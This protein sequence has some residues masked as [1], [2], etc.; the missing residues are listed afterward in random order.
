MMAFIAAYLPLI[1]LSD[2]FVSNT[3]S[4]SLRGDEAYVTGLKNSSITSVTV[5]ATVVY[6]Y[7]ERESDGSTRTKTKTCD[8]TGIAE[9]AFAESRNLQQIQL[10]EGLKVI[11]PHAFYSCE[12]LTSITIPNSV[13]SIGGF[14][15]AESG[16][17]AII[18]GTGVAQMGECAL[19]FSSPSKTPQVLF[20]G[21]PPEYVKYYTY[22]TFHTI[23]FNNVIG[24][25]LSKYES[26]WGN[27]IS[28]R[29]WYGL[30][31]YQVALTE[32][33]SVTFNGMGGIGTM[34]S[35]E[36]QDGTS[37]KLSKN[38]YRKDGY[39][40]QGWAESKADADNGRVKFRDEEEIAID[41]NKTLYAVWFFVDT[42]DKPPTLSVESADWTD[43]TITLRCEDANVG[44]ANAPFYNLLYF[45][46]AKDEWCNVDRDDLLILYPSVESNGEGGEMLVTRITDKKFAKRNNG[47]GTVKYSI[48][49]DDDNAR[50]ATCVTRNRHCG[51]KR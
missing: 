2:G 48:Y 44:I 11:E 40:F 50:M 45:D 28:S 23:A 7:T 47:F 49:D 39:V 27:V 4:Y 10:S 22:D 5:P 20:M 16:L 43:G 38:T 14:A 30:Y 19:Q 42:T 6:E 17:T 29:W 8:V 36:F 32:T 21:R 12:A 13:T 34:S 1:A 37:Q 9:M 51:L 15:F 18:V 46:T 25:Y 24:L 41:A 26:E 33:H 31:M 3:L 35:Q